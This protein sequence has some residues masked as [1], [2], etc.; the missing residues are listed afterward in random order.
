MVNGD[1]YVPRSG[2]VGDWSLLAMTVNYIM[3]TF[4]A[5][6]I[7]HIHPTI[8]PASESDRTSSGMIH[9][10]RLKIPSRRYDANTSVLPSR[11]PSAGPTSAIRQMIQTHEPYDLQND[12]VLT[13]AFL[14]PKNSSPST[15]QPDKTLLT[16]PNTTPL[17]DTPES[18]DLNLLPN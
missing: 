3:S 18:S 11:G 2:G 6:S 5:I 16:A 9:R 17:R 1:Q 7:C 4:T 15:L 14:T 8:Y 10:M 13:I 12:Q